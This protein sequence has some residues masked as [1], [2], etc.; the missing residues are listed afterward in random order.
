MTV[1]IGY[2]FEWDPRKN[3]ANAGKHGVSFEVATEAFGDPDRV[4]AL[5]TRH[6][7]NRETRWFC[8][9]N[10]RGHV[11]T[12]RFTSRGGVIRIFGSG[13]WRFGKRRYEER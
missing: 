7:T 8:Y 2:R 13:Y 5:D 6:T 9:A 1:L 11:L 4:L 10:V 3:I 12:V